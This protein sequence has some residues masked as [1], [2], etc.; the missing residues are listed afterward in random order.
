M[1]KTAGSIFSP[2]SGSPIKRRVRIRYD[3][4]LAKPLAH[5]FLDG[6][7]NDNSEYNRHGTVRNV[8]F[9]SGKI[10]KAADFN[11]TDSQFDCNSS[12]IGTGSVTLTAWIKPRGWGGL[13][14]GRIF[15]NGTLFL[16]LYE[17]NKSIVFHRG[18]N[19]IIAPNNSIV[20]HAWNWVAVTQTAL[21]LV[22]MYINNVLVSDP[23]EDGGLPDEGVPN[24]AIGC[25]YNYD[26]TQ[27]FDGLIDD[28]RIYRQILSQAK[29]DTIWNERNGTQDQV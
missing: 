6:N 12:F 4:P 11:G 17:T 26:D 25:T 10:F 2:D 24:L 7:A 19:N 3:E 5:Y 27:T 13:G 8:S 1:V 16:Y 14:F 22:N 23:D 9:V 28:A 29:F 20:L 15:D 21:G 18:T